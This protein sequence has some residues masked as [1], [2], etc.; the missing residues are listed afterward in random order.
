METTNPELFERLISEALQHAFSGWDFS[1]TAGRWQEGIPTWDYAE[2]VRGY[3]KPDISLLDMDTGGGEILSSFMPLPLNTYATEKYL[4]NVPVARHR[5]EP[6]G[7]NVR[8]VFDN[9]HLPF[10]GDFFDLAINRH[11]S[12]ST[13]EL[14]R[15][16]KPGGFFITQQVGAKNNFEINE[17]LQEHP[18]TKYAF[19]NLALATSKLAAAGFQIVVQREEFPETTIEDIG[20]LVYYLKAVPWQITDFSVEKYRDP[21]A[22]IHNRIQESGN[23]KIRSHRFL[24]VA[25]KK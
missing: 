2:I 24:I 13:Q 11:G 14:H 7:V 17:L 6:L 19:W 16:L 4:P 21:L 22:A 18:E 20:A 25:K 8:Q 5:L 9:N 10:E 15:I 3:L 12:F 23:L 1:Y